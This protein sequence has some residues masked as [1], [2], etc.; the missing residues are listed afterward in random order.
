MVAPS[1]K[2]LDR[3]FGRALGEDATFRTWFLSQ[4]VNGQGYETLV[5]CRSDHPWAKIRLIAPNPE[6]GALEATEKE[7]ETDILAVFE[8]PSGRRL[9]V[10]VENKIVTGSFRPLQPDMYAARAEHWVENQNYG[11][12]HHWETV[13]LAPS[14]FM[15]KNSE[16]ARK[17]TTRIT[18]ELV[19][20]YIPLFST[21]QSYSCPICG[22]PLNPNPRYPRYVCRACSAKAVAPNG[23]RLLFSNVDMSGGYTAKYADTGFD[24]PSH[25]CLID[26]VRCHADEARFGGI[27]IEVVVHPEKSPRP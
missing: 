10:H 15:I 22:T 18:H 26:G 1:E 27:V 20:E 19:A 24:Y 16:E 11:G 4:L 14:E 7:G 21:S 12:Y 2:D 8:N 3:E 23:Q 6:T 13:L 9:G 17:F 5:K 25:E